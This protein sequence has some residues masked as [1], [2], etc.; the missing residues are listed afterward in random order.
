M[1]CSES[2]FFH[3][4]RVFQPGTWNYIEHILDGQW[5][6]YRC[7]SV[8]HMTICYQNEFED[9][10]KTNKTIPQKVSNCCIVF[11]HFFSKCLYWP[12]KPCEGYK[13]V[14]IYVP[15]KRSLASCGSLNK[16]AGTGAQCELGQ[17]LIS[18]QLSQYE[19]VFTALNS[20]PL[21]PPMPRSNKSNY[22][23]IVH[24]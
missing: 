8:L 13:T 10:T 24:G 4:C 7:L 19:L 11:M 5:E 18:L 22:D 17:H 3:F 14:C 15:A 23:L 2:F 12:Q 6:R 20:M 1:S 16:Y 21:Y 9:G